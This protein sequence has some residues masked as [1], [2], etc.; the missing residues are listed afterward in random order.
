M[1]VKLST[2]WF[3]SIFAGVIRLSVAKAIGANNLD[4]LFEQWMAVLA[5]VVSITLFTFIMR[6]AEAREP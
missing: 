3:A 5:F 6:G 4:Q 1:Y 2:L